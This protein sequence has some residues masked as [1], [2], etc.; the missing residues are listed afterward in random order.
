MKQDIFSKSELKE[1][2]ALVRNAMLESLPEPEQCKHSFSAEFQEKTDQLQQAEEK[3]TRRN[4]FVKRSI[5]AVLAIVIGLTMLLTLNAEV[6]AAVTSWS[7][8]TF[9]GKS[10]YWFHGEKEAALPVFEPAWIPDG[11]E[12]V[13]DERNVNS[14]VMLY[15][16]GD[17]PK[18]GFTFDYGF[19]RS[20]SPLTV[21]T[22]GEDFYVEKVELNGNFGELYASSD[23]EESHALA[24]ID[25]TNGVVFTITSYLDPNV[26][27]HIAEEVKLVK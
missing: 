1:A 3:R 13:Y 7:K 20:D 2:A 19:M 17:D 26:I 15:Q 22:Y 9:G 4:Q 11:Y 23:P 10:T 5:A 16:G 18:D 27:L 8:E 12:I 14:H 24:W 21:D 25:E 6:R